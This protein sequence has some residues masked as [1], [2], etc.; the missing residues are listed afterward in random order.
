MLGFTRTALKGHSFSSAVR[1]LPNDRALVPEG[2]EGRRNP[3]VAKAANSLARYTA[4]LKPCPFKARFIP[5]GY[6]ACL[7][8][9][10]LG[11]SSFA[12]AQTITGTVTNGTTGKP[13]AGDAVTLLALSQG[14]T[15][16][17]STK[18]DAQGRFSFPAPPDKGPHMVRATHQGVN[19]FPQTGPL[20]PGATSAQLTVYDSAKK[21]EGVTQTV[22]VDRLQSDGKQVQGIDR[23]SVV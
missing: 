21:V 19:Y 4:R 2:D 23:K 8:A 14:M 22:E 10:I 13:S 18:T 6:C 12:A 16:L 7:L 5:R 17:S 3:S 9:C 11:L 1:T 15:E 20:M